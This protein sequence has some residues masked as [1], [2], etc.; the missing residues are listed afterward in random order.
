LLGKLPSSGIY[1]NMIIKISK[2]VLKF[3]LLYASSIIAFGFGFHILCS[4]HE[5]F[6]DPFSS[7][8]YMLAMMVGEFNFGDVFIR[9]GIR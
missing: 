6:K 1:I 7:V 2:D 5:H 8:L 9:S 4:Q 3:F